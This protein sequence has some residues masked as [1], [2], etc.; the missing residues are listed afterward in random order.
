MM[1]WNLCEL[2]TRFL[3]QIKDALLESYSEEN[4]SVSNFCRNVM[5]AFFRSYDEQEK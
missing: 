4:V 2:M 5:I 3:I 1:D